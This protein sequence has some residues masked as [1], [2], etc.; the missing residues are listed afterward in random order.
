MPQEVGYTKRCHHLSS[1]FHAH[2]I[3]PDVNENIME[4]QEHQVIANEGKIQ[5]VGFPLEE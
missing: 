4:E 5:Q 3:K 2:L 1:I